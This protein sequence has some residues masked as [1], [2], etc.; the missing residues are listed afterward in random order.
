MRSTTMDLSPNNQAIADELHAF[1][2]EVEVT[3]KIKNQASAS[4]SAFIK[5]NTIKQLIAIEVPQQISAYIHNMN[6]IKI[7]MEVDTEPPGNFSTEAKLLLLPIPFSVLTFSLP[8]LFA[9]KL[10][11]LLCRA[12]KNRIK[13]RD[14]Y[15]F[16]WYMSR[17]VP[18]HL[19]HLETRLRQS[20]HWTHEEKLTDGSLK[21][22]LNEKMNQLIL[23]LQKRMCCLL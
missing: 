19:A 22:L 20:G 18:V 2:F 5:A 6:I 3:S 8:D 7:K 16:V 13:G 21:Q 1:G 14:W 4:E 9:G 17:H 12:W 11:A 15:D 10:H 23:M